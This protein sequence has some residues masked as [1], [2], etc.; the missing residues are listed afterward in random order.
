MKLTYLFGIFVLSI[1][2]FSC[3]KCI[4]CSYTSISEGEI[5]EEVCG[6]SDETSDFENAVAD[7]AAV[8]RS[9]YYCEENY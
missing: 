1:T 4:T 2:L 6:K 3:N 8:H 5:S 9:K 7:S